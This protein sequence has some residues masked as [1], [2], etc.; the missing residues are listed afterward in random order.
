MMGCY[1]YQVLDTIST[2]EIPHDID[3]HERYPVVSISFDPVNHLEEKVAGVF[4]G[5]TCFH[6]TIIL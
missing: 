4:Q 3:I 2:G 1:G 6:Q 5:K